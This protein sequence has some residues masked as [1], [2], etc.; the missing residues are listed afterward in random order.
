VIEGITRGE[1]QVTKTDR[2]YYMNLVS[3]S[4]ELLARARLVNPDGRHA[5]RMNPTQEFHRFAAAFRQARE[6][7]LSDRLIKR[8]RIAGMKEVA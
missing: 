3:D 5:D 6:A 7:G 1:V 2:E 4:A 8:A